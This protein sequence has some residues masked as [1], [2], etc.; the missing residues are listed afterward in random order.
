MTE[1]TIMTSSDSN[2]DDLSALQSVLKSV[3]GAQP[4]SMYRQADFETVED[5]DA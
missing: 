1:K 2:D 3:R 4:V 5:F